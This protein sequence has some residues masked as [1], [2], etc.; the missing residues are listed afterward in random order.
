MSRLSTPDFLEDTANYLRK[1]I[2]F[3]PEEGW[4]YVRGRLFER[5]ALNR[6]SPTG[7]TTSR[8]P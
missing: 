1:G 5:N 7:G 2:H 4:S 8:I 6:R 3:M